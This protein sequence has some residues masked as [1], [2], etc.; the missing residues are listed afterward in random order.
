MHQNVGIDMS[1]LDVFS[2]NIPRRLTRT[3]HAVVKHDSE[4]GQHKGEMERWAMRGVRLN[5]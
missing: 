3:N 1:V 2:E 4:T 5:S